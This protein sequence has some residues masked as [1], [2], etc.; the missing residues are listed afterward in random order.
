M[1]ERCIYFNTNALSRKLNAL[2]EETFAQV[3]LP[4]SHGYLLRLVLQEPGLSQHEIATE[5]RLNKSTVA[6]FV[7][8]LETNGLLTR[9]A[10]ECDQRENL[11][12]PTNKAKAMQTEMEILGEELYKLVCKKFNKNKVKH[13]V[14]LA[15]EIS[16]KF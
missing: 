10:S 5:L 2:W 14:A 13:F 7:N 16:E 8:K 15:R 11:I 3:G 4:P 12:H 1:F 6:R 9:S